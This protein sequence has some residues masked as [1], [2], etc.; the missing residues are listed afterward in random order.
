MQSLFP[1][2]DYVIDQNVSGKTTAIPL[3]AI[4]S[5][6]GLYINVFQMVAQAH[7]FKLVECYSIILAETYNSQPVLFS[8]QHMCSVWKIGLSY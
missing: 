5:W 4:Y 7:L 1:Y 2:N 6:E 8:R 3:T